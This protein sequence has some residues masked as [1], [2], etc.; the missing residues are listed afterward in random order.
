MFRLSDPTDR[1]TETHINIKHLI[2]AQI[3]EWIEK[4]LQTPNVEEN[5]AI[6]LG[7]RTRTWYGRDEYV[8]GCAL[9]LAVI[10]KMGSADAAL[11]AYKEDGSDGF[12]T[13]AKLL[14]IDRELGEQINCAHAFG[15][16]KASE[17]ANRLRTAPDEHILER[18]KTRTPRM[19][20]DEVFQTAYGQLEREYD[21]Y[22]SR[23]DY[24][25][26]VRRPLSIVYDAL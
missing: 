9:G 21:A 20:A 7:G 10:G 6:F 1:K 2:K 17:I 15:F 25:G 24:G 5:R 13:C 8:V 23:L 12:Q 16:M 19:N 22:R 18:A 4:G 11:R 3:A 14:G 26:Y